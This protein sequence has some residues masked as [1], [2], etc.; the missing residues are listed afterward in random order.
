MLEESHNDQE[1]AR[2]YPRRQRRPNQPLKLADP[3][4]KKKKTARSTPIEKEPLPGPSGILATKEIEGSGHNVRF[5]GIVKYR[6][7]PRRA[8]AIPGKV[9]VSVKD[10]TYYIPFTLPDLVDPV[11]SHEDPHGVERGV[12]P[13]L[14]EF[15]AKLHDSP[16]NPLKTQI[17]EGSQPAT[18]KLGDTKATNAYTTSKERAQRP[19]RGSVFPAAARQGASKMGTKTQK[20][21]T[22]E[23]VN[24]LEADTDVDSADES[25]APDHTLPSTIGLDFQVLET[26]P[27]YF[28]QRLLL[29]L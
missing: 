23:K 5:D 2:R 19:C 15:S 18:K 17:K 11:Y 3:R 12:G 25:N 1:G 26:L 20:Q 6:L 9:A 16:D 27:T 13:F 21:T 24:D 28:D 4:K 14:V 8:D 10:D 29:E 22:S 7:V